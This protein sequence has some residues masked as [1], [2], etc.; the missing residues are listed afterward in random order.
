MQIHSHASFQVPVDWSGENIYRLLLIHLTGQ[1]QV[2]WSLQHNRLRHLHTFCML[3]CIKF[4]TWWWPALLREAKHQEEFEA[5]ARVALFKS[6]SLLTTREY[7]TMIFSFPI[8]RFLS[9]L[10]L[11]EC[12]SWTQ[13]LV[14]DVLRLNH[15]MWN[16]YPL[17]LFMKSKARGLRKNSKFITFWM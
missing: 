6:G 15:I 14:F 1:Y 7:L 3:I 11:L 9:P 16:E 4:R 12:N 13:C 17:V 10:A 8:I 2:S 5:D